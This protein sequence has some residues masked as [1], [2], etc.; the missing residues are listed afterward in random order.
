MNPYDIITERIIAMLESGT[1]PWSKTWKVQRGMPR[2]MVSGR[3]YRGINVWLLHSAQYESPFWLTY[4]QATELGGNIKRGEKSMPAVFWKLA[5]VAD[6]KTGE[7]VKIPLLRYYSVFNLAQVEGL[8]ATPAIEAKEPTPADQIVAGYPNA[9]KINH[10]MAAAFYD[11]SADAIGMP[12]P[13]RFNTQADYFGTLFHEMAHSTGHSRRLN[14]L[15]PAQYGS[16]NYSKEELVAEMCSAFLCAQAGLERHLDNSASY[17]AGWLKALKND[18]KLV[19]N[20][21]ACAQ[22]AADHILNIKHEQPT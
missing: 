17:I 6:Q 13:S 20:A 2:N 5:E 11:P 10:G 16:E 3:A 21:A 12:L 4:R 15:V 22:K 18:H 19:V 7:E 1:A 8:K 14:R 9:P